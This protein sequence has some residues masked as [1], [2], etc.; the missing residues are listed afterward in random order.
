[1]VSFGQP[2]DPLDTWYVRAN[3]NLTSVAFGNDVFVATGL[4]T[5]VISTNGVVWTRVV[6]PLSV[7][8]AYV[9]FLRDFFVIRANTGEVLI[10][11]NGLRWFNTGQKVYFESIAA[12]PDRFVAVSADGALLSYDGIDWTPTIS[13]SSGYLPFKEVAFGNA[14]FV[15]TFW[16]GA[17]VSTDGIVWIYSTP[18]PECC[19]LVFGNGIFLSMSESHVSS[20]VDGLH[21]SA[22]RQLPYD[23]NWGATYRDVTFGGG[24]FVA[25]G[26]GPRPPGFQLLSNVVSSVD[27]MTWKWH[28]AATQPGSYNELFAVAYGHGTFVAV[29][30]QFII[31]SAPLTDSVPS[32]PALT[33]NSYAGVR[34]EGP[35]G[36]W[37]R[38]ERT[39]NLQNSNVYTAVTN[40]YLP[41]TP[42]TW[43]DFD[44]PNARNRFYRAVVLP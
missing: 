31:Q 35:A 33:L 22:R 37:Y 30:G 16:Y 44:S 6:T 11:T 24:R 23:P 13:Q 27:G 29:G 40:I 32:Q 34:I 10:S 25:V 18:P 9:A 41:S 36:K 43:I 14:L 12:A 3:Y 15:A 2:T 39:D 4:N 17:I 20:S 7:G 8:G 28:G 19:S 21:W 26:A 38:I 42:A 1:M 5:V